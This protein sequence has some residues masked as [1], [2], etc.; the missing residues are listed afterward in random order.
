MYSCITAVW[1]M[2]K[3]V[4]VLTVVQLQLSR[5]ATTTGMAYGTAVP[6]RNATSS[7]SHSLVHLSLTPESMIK[8]DYLTSISNRSFTNTV[9]YRYIYAVD[10][11]VYCRRVPCVS[12]TVCE[13]ACRHAR[14][15]AVASW[16]ASVFACTPALTLV[17]WCVRSTTYSCSIQSTMVQ[18]INLKRSTR[19]ASSSN[20]YSSTQPR[21][22]HESAHD[23]GRDA[24]VELGVDGVGFVGLF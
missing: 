15:C 9:Y 24:A 10:V 12:A 18:H 1:C 13:V 16:R 19:P 22:H 23:Q 3:E 20:P 7:R 21:G 4:R 8:L 17:G 5:G 14:Q 2:L 6:Y 11:A